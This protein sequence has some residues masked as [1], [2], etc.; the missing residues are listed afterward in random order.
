MLSRRIGIIVLALLASQEANADCVIS[1]MKPTVPLPTMEVGQEFSFI[2][3]GCDT[4]LFQAGT[5]SKI[6]KAGP[7]RGSKDLTYKVVLTER[8]WNHLVAQQT[9]STLEW[10]ISGWWTVS[11]R[12]HEVVVTT[13]NELKVDGTLTMSMSRADAKLVG[14]E[15]DGAGESI[16]GAG[17]VNAD[18]HDDVL[19]GAPGN[20]NGGYLAGAAYLVLGPVHGTVDLSSAT[21][22]LVG[23]KGSEEAGASV[24]GAGDVDGDGN[25]DVLVGAYRY[26]AGPD[27]YAG[28]AY[29]VLGPVRGTLDLSRADAKLVGEDLDDFAGFDVSGAGD[30]DGD[31]RDDVLIGAMGV[32]DGGANAGAAYVLL[33]P[34]T[35]RLT[36]SMADAEIVGEADGDQMGWSVSGAGDT[37]GDGLA[38]LLLGVYDQY[39]GGAYAGAAY[40]VRGPVTG[41]LDL[42]LAD[43]KLVGEAAFDFAGQSVSGAGDV[44]G[45]G[46]DDLLIGATGHDEGHATGSPYAPGAAYLVSG[47]VTGTVDLSLAD[48]KLL[49]DEDEDAAGFYVSGTGDVDGD[50]HH[51][52]LVGAPGHG[53]GGIAYLVLGPATGT[54]GLSLS[55]AKFV[56][57]AAYDNAGAVS[58]A[59][60]VDGDGRDD[61]LIS[62][63]NAEGGA[64][65]G[66][67]YLFYGGGL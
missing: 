10:R 17:D 5:L 34:V 32:D 43:A 31:G 3:S 52:L 39:E 60:D 12:T 47:S 41:I 67:A 27:A 42:S 58:G 15:G 61:V 51:D 50:G 13:M 28:A 53:A 4:L 16:S 55:D 25:D 7:D 26:N 57:E 18:G 54:I 62:S 2:A 49:G 63:N 22:E 40:L 9:S 38:D 29:L 44:D 46:H 37:D 65:A 21:A 66:A 8:E 23:E 24:S 36:P 11:E 6:P 30:V 48:A 56:G 14:K 1:G 64:G 45:D 59:G 35:G 33:G 19:V 20:D